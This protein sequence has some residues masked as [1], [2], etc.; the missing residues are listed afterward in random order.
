MAANTK[1]TF[2]PK[3]PVG[4]ILVTTNSSN[5]STYL[6]YGTWTLLE[7]G[8]ILKSTRTSSELGQK[9]GSSSHTHSVSA[10][11]HTVNSH[12]H[13]VS[14]HS[15]TVNSHSHSIPS[16]KHAGTI[17]FDNNAYFVTNLWGHSLQ[18]VTNNSS[19]EGN[20]FNNV[21]RTKTSPVRV[22]NTNTWSGTS[23][24]SSPGTNSAGG[25]NTGSSSPGTNSA[26]GGNT[27]STNIDP[28]HIKV[29]MWQRTA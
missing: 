17:G 13:S 14:A 2:A 29:Y 21:N 24:T 3:Y 10:H 11:S 9:A 20:S 23:G 15:H 5:P 8:R 19:T 1:I 6:Y 18:T 25:G 4:H 26:G 12:T 27:G 16:H 22:S 28:P 7:A